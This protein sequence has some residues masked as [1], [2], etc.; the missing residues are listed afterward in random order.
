MNRFLQALQL[1]EA[2]GTPLWL[3]IINAT[4]DSFSDGGRCLI[5]AA[6][7]SHARDLLASGCLALDVGGVSTRPGAADISV[8]DE[9]ARVE[10]VLTALRRE[11]PLVPLSLDTSSPA[12][13]RR[14]ATLG[15]VDLANDVWAGR[16]HDAVGTKDTTIAACADHSLPIALMHMQ[17]TPLTMQAAPQYQDLLEEVCA[18]LAERARTALG[19]GVPSVLV[20]PGIGFGKTREH[21]LTLLSEEAMARLC[22]LGYPV[23]VG[24]SRKR[25]LARSE[26]D[27]PESRDGVSKEWESRAFARGA[28]V[29]RTH[30]GPSGFRSDGLPL[31]PPGSQ[32]IR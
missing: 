9:W 28:R 18:F 22:A 31:S 10:P 14:A 5:G 7:V 1:C 15:L 29:L 8:D 26:G 24:L 32:G 6:A 25:F 2:A 4:P 20:D 11:F 17:G 16:K 23:L 12:V 3:G 13:L 19:E 27:S 30:S 21:N